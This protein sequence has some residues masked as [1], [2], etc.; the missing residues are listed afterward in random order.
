M[1]I[2]IAAAGG[3]DLDGGLLVGEAG[4]VADAL[5]EGL[6]G[7]EERRQVLEKH[8]EGDILDHCLHGLAIL[9]EEQEVRPQEGEGDGGTPWEQYKKKSSIS[10]RA[11]HSVLCP[12]ATSG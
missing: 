1:N 8:F 4:H 3:L 11:F 12:L 5:E 10:L 7:V 6:V 9:R 2:A